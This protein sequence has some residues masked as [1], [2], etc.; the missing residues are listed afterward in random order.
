MGRNAQDSPDLVPLAR[1]DRSHDRLAAV[2]N[3]LVR[4]DR[5]FS[6]EIDLALDP[7]LAA[8][9]CTDRIAWGAFERE[10]AAERPDWWLMQMTASHGPGTTLE[11]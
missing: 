5:L 6:R 3:L 11:A 9:P 7:G 1:L 4:H 8:A 2:R 10:I